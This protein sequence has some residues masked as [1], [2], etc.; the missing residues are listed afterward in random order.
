MA[1]GFAERVLD[2]FRLGKRLGVI[3]VDSPEEFARSLYSF[4]QGLSPSPISKPVE[5]E[6]TGK[7]DVILS[8]LQGFSLKT[9]I[10]PELLEKDT[11][12]PY[13]RL[14]ITSGCT[15][16]EACINMCPTG[17]IQKHGG[18]IDFMYGYCIACTLCE[19]ACPEKALKLERILDL[20]SLVDQR[21][22]TVFESEVIACVHC[23]K[24]YITKAAYDRL[25]RALRGNLGGDFNVESQ[26]EL[27]KYCE[28]CRPMKALEKLGLL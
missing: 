11:G 21:P 8:L 20:S 14:S 6:K 22:L 12:Y 26:L 25:S 15:V 17:A 10:R 27:L 13:A 7:R 1:A 28:N 2:D 3:R 4:Y 16:C 19:Q 9:G 24:P 23:K 18:R 5:L